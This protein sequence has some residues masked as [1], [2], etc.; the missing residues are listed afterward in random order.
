MLLA[1]CILIGWLIALVSSLWSLYVCASAAQFQYVHVN[2]HVYNMFSFRC[3]YVHVQMWIICVHMCM[4]QG[5]GSDRCTTMGIH[6]YATGL[7]FRPLYDFGFVALDILYT[8]PEDNGVYTCKA[9]N[10]C[11]SD[12]TQTQPHCVGESINQSII[13]G[14][15]SI[16]DIR[17]VSD[18]ESERE[19]TI[20]ICYKLDKIGKQS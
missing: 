11:G 8:Y 19:R 1:F 5:T 4:L 6:V 14:S 7:R 3:A 17:D 20:F 18:W 10:K 15:L 13:I 16:A 12:T 9:T 2:I